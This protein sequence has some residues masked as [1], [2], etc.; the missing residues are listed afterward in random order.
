MQY[1]LASASKEAITSVTIGHID[2]SNS[3]GFKYMNDHGIR[4]VFPGNVM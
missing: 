3:Y 1:Q 4:T 2:I